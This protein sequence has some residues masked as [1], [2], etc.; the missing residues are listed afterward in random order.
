MAGTPIRI[1]VVFAPDKKPKPVWFELNRQ[2]HDVKEVTY[3]WRDKIGEAHLLHFA[4]TSDGA[5]YE[6]VF[7]LSDQSWTLHRQ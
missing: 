5:L 4:V 3:H 7:N 1:G 2:K 6:L